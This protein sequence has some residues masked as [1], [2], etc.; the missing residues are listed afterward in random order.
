MEIPVG[1][2]LAVLGAALLHASWNVL[3]KSGEDKELESISIAVGSGFLALVIAPF[4]PAPA[5]ASWPWLAGSAVVHILYFA[6]LA[7]AYR[8]G[9]LSYTYPVMRGGGPMIVALVGAVALGEVLPMKETLG[10]VLICAGVLAFATGRHHPRATGFA[11][12]NAV[13]IATYTLLDGNG[14]R[15]SGAPV[16]YTLWFFAANGIVLLLYGAARGRGAAIAIYFRTKWMRALIGGLLALGAYGIAIWAMTRAPIALVAVLRETAV[17]FAAV[18]SA[19]FLREK[20]TRRR[21]LA[22]GAVMVGLVVL[23]I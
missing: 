16:S 14:A 3:L 18:L 5:S 4:L 20:M 22:T 11:I 12:A 6:F 15:V 1:V 17:I 19:I 23:R 7:G 10:V 8:W 2:T 21:L 9:E 13:V